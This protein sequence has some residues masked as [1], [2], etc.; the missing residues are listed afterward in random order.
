MK[1]SDL[2]SKI[3][4]GCNIDE[5]YL[6][7][8]GDGYF[9][10]T[11]DNINDDVIVEDSNPKYINEGKLQFKYDSL[12]NEYLDYG[13]YL[14]Y[15]DDENK[16]HIYRYQNEIKNRVLASLDF[17][18]IR[19]NSSYFDNFLKD[20]DGRNYFK[21]KINILYEKEENYENFFKKISEI[22]IR[23]TN[24]LIVEK[25]FKDIDNNLKDFD[26]KR[27]PLNPSD[28]KFT[29]DNVSIYNVVKR[30]GRGAINLFTD[31]QRLQN[32]WSL[33]AKSRLIESILVRFPIPAFY[34]D[35]S[36]DEQWLVI[37]GLQ[38][39]S[40]ISQFYQNGF[41]L[42]KLEYLTE[43][44]GMYFK[45]LSLALQARIEETNITALKILSGT[46]LRV[47]YS[48]FERINTE[49]KP[50]TSQ[51]LRHA[52]NS[53]AGGQPSNFIAELSQ[54][55]IFK[56][57][58]GNRNKDRMQDRETVLRYVAFKLTNYNEYQ[59]PIK[60]F[61]DEG[62][63]KIYSLTKYR[64]DDLKNEFLEGLLLA[65]QLFREDIFLI[66]DQGGNKRFNNP[67]F[68][69]ISVIFSDIVEEK[70]QKIRENIDLFNSFFKE[71]IESTEF[72]NIIRD[73]N[74]AYSV[75]GVQKRFRTM[76][77]LVNLIA[78]G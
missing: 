37:D 8:D 61:L 42:Q 3:T 57:V 63:A 35:C 18:I 11:K 26:L 7:P 74:D 54:Q 27:Q 56:E 52:I 9:Y 55:T 40:T 67:L 17:I 72:G 33:E 47:K 59:P 2:T 28:I 70:R 23:I 71:L 38:R 1:L 62:M 77:E 43:L 6:R 41:S 22:E 78:E 4:L 15:Q 19:T 75:D 53:F 5:R 60:D 36:N 66:E 32:L 73:H 39:L 13:D 10:L 46:P 76:K 16:F 65:K 12:K 31:F 14:I 44:E 45:D 49:G 25:I 58:W 48:L 51:E 21:E 64:L 69:V 29:T 68:E 20:K 30:I 34:F 50:L 24:E